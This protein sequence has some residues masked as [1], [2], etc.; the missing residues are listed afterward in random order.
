MVDR[1]TNR[2]RGEAFSLFLSLMSSCLFLSL[3]CLLLSLFISKVLFL[4]A[5]WGVG[6]GFVIYKNPEDA[7]KALGI[8]KDLGPNV[9]PKP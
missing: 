8:H 1:E 3:F 4:F 5:Y 6:F 2:P 9:N 7:E